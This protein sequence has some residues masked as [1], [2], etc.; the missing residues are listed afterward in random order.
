MMKLKVLCFLALFS[1]ANY[2]A[3]HPVQI[4]KGE[5]I[6]YSYKIFKDDAFISQGEQSV[7]PGE[8]AYFSVEE[9]SVSMS[10]MSL[11]II[12]YERNGFL[13]S[14]LNFLYSETVS[15][16]TNDM[17]KY[18]QLTLKRPLFLKS[19]EQRTLRTKDGKF[20]LLVSGRVSN[21]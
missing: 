16:S 20:T 9:K 8:S 7:I 14:N 1:S 15:A 12:S 5:I 17:R 11:C 3:T 19:G 21:L 13:Y 4:Q 18:R 6:N 10:D 2:A